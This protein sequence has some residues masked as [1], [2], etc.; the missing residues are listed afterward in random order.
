MAGEREDQRIVEL[1]L[2]RAPPRTEGARRAAR[3]RI[4][5]AAAPLLARRRRPATSWDV[6]AAW[7]RPGLVAASVAALLILGGLQA[8]RLTQ[9]RTPPTAAE[10]LA[11]GERGQLPTLLVARSEPDADALL[12][13]ALLSGNGS[14]ARLPA[15]PHER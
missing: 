11:A 10:V 15:V 6:L 3:D 4:H 8:R 1:E 12:A 14:A 7:A 9:P 2:L 5:A 13:A